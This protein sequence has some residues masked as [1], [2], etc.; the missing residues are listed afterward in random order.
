M[1]NISHI[2]R[3]GRKNREG[4]PLK[5][6]PGIFVCKTCGIAYYKKSWHAKLDYERHVHGEK[7]PVTFGYCPA[8]ELSQDKMFRGKIGIY[9]I[10]SKT[11]DELTSAIHNLGALAQ[12]RNPLDRILSLVHTSQ[13]LELTTSANHLAEHITKKIEH[14]FKPW[15]ISMYRTG[16]NNE[17]IIIKIDFQTK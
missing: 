11:L 8:C 7:S 16:T 6:Q 12:E 4:D 10:P 17:I 14:T 2:F 13:M 9:N 1:K 15:R 5:G 3:L